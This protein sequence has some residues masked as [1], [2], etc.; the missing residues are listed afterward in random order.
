[1]PPRHN[2]ELRR[3]VPKVAF[4]VRNW[5]E[6]QA[7]L[8]RRGSLTLWIA[9]RDALAGFSCYR[10]RRQPWVISVDRGL[11]LFAEQLRLRREC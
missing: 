10:D 7:E 2:D 3:H 11:L 4:K 8:R 1:M 5:T 6:Y 9:Y